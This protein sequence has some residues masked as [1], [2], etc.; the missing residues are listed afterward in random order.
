MPF[1]GQR[2]TLRAE[3]YNLFNRKQYGFPVTDLAAANFGAILGGST[4][5]NDGNAT[6][7]GPRRVQ[8]ALRYIF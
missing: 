8:L 3:I 7:I 6:S 5:Y 1:E 2:L 4:L